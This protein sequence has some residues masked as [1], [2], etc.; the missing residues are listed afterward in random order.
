MDDVS[1]GQWKLANPCVDMER[2]AGTEFLSGAFLWPAFIAASASEIA[3]EFAGL[4]LGSGPH[5]DAIEPPWATP[6]K[7]ALD[8]RSVRL[9][10]FSIASAGPVTLVCAPFALHGASIAD[11]A[12]DH[13]LVGAL[14]GAGLDRVFV[15]DWCSADAEM[16]FH[17]VDSYLADLNVAVDRVGGAVD[18]IGLCQGGWMALIYAAR[19]PAKVRKLVLAGAPI[20]LA[21]GQSYL[22]HLARATPL[23]IFKELVEFGEGAP[24]G[25]AGATRP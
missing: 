23:A 19:F 10:D 18:L 25:P 15:T 24:G 5:D 17:S 20:D 8:L 3:K 7:M 13:S 2:L 1:A 6:K 9:R 21:A 16:G 11:F 22:S 14:L 12:P 4:A